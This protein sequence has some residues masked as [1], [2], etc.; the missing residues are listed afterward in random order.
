MLNG[1]PISWRS[2]LQAITILSTIESEYIGIFEA[3]KEAMWLKD[4]QQEMG[5]AQGMVRVYFDNQSILSLVQNLVYHARTKHIDI[6]YHR[7]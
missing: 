4:L 6:R 5:I 2:S 7:I 1:G 3:A